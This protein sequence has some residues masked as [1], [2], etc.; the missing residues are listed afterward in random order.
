MHFLSNVTTVDNQMPSPKRLVSAVKPSKGKLKQPKN[1]CRRRK[2][3]SRS[4]KRSYKLRYLKTL[5]A[6]FK[7]RWK[8]CNLRSGF[9]YLPYYS[10]ILFERLSN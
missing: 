10:I 2:L 3:T 5:Y 4:K 8:L 9:V 1:G 6:N 7:R